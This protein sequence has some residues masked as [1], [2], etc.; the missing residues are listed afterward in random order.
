MPTINKL[1]LLGTP[2][3]G[4]Q[5]PVYAPNSGDARRLSINGLTDY[6]QD[7]LDLPDSSD[8]VSFLQ[9]GTGAVTRTVQSKLRDVVSVRDFGAVGDGVTDD[10]AAIQAAIEASK[11]VRAAYYA[12]DPATGTKRI[13]LPAGVY[14]ISSPL[15][16]YSFQE[17]VGD[18]P[19]TL[20]KASGGFSGTA[21]ILLKSVT[22]ATVNWC[23]GTVVSNLSFIASVAA[24]RQSASNILNCLFSN[25]TFTT[26]YGLMLDSYTQACVI[27]R[28]YSGGSIDQIVFLKGNWNLIE[29]IDKEQ[30]TGATTEAYV[31]LANHSAFPSYSDGNTLRRILIEGTG[32]VNKTPIKL[33]GTYNTTIYDFWG[34]LSTNN[35]Y[36]LDIA[37]SQEVNLKGTLR[38]GASATG[39]IKLSSKS[40]VSLDFLSSDAENVP[41]YSYLD[42]D[43]TSYINIEKVYSRVSADRIRL[44]KSANI[45]V[46]EF[47]DSTLFR[48][49]VAGM[50]PYSAPQYLNAQNLLINPSFEAGRHGW[51]FYGA[52]SPVP[53]TEEYIASEV[54]PGLMGHFIWSGGGS[55]QFVQNITLS[56]AQVGKPMTIS[57]LVK[58][59]GAS[60]SRIV[61]IVAGLYSTTSYQATSGSGWQVITMTA[62]PTASG[63]KDFGFYFLSLNTTAEVW[64]DEVS[65]SFG[66]LAPINAAKFGSLELNGKTFTTLS[67]A[68]TTGTW[69]VGDHVFNSAPAVGSPKGWICTV[70]G[71]PG[72][73]VSEGN[74]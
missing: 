7:A 56:A 61:P 19:G 32:S 33:Y 5:L 8:E 42:V 65:V 10:T 62:Y 1:P 13:Y 25:L 22:P 39:K 55:F 59:T 50:T 23:V 4:D 74:L 11:Q 41:F 44:D 67:A 51:N 17:F 64:V 48:T 72:T 66:E 53:T 2:S 6:L 71:T 37:E 47:I 49:P 68:P 40:Y 31:E 73:W 36:Q 52:G 29:D 24:I 28:I 63:A 15:S 20:L 30:G 43:S 57:A 12:L 27:N 38:L 3:G 34:E 46:L 9:A 18:G 54:A 35:G 69:K 16:L 58:I 21:L 26:T 45:K 70:A 60:N 14:L